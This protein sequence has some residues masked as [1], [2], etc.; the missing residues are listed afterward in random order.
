M[1]SKF[2]IA[3]IKRTA[4]NVAPLLKKKENLTVKIAEMQREIETITAT[5]ADYDAPIRRE[6]GYG[7]EDLVVRET[8][9][10]GTDAQGKPVMASKWVLKYPETVIPVETGAPDSHEENNAETEIV[11]DVNE[12]EVSCG[13][14]G[15]EV[16]AS[17]AEDTAEAQEVTTNTDTELSSW[18]NN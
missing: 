14:D 4:Q 13:P 11:P 6:T 12:A 1:F 3:S 18:L 10:A 5:I 8:Y 2:F 15:C 16:T 17:N 7:V 9:Q